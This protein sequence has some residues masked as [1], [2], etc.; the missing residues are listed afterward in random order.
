MTLFPAFGI[1]SAVE[2][3]D[4]RYVDEFGRPIPKWRPLEPE[5]RGRHRTFASAIEA[6]AR[7]LMVERNP[8]FDAVVDRWNELFPGSPARP[9]RSDGGRI[10]LYV[11]S[12]PALFAFR[13]R[14]PAVK[15]ALASLPGAPE[16]LDVRLEIHA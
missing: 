14:L 5:K 8:F 1:I 4:R 7:E 13:P 12:A 3:E 11:R 15:R 16:R 9:G 6:A 2:S 10:V